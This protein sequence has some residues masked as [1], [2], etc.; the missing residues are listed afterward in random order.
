VH[1][2]EAL[3]TAAPIRRKVAPDGRLESRVR[4]PT[5]AWVRLHSLDDPIREA[6]EI[7]DRA[8]DGRPAPPIVTAI[9]VGTAAIVDEL[10]RRHPDTRILALELF[11]DVP[12]ALRA[13]ARTADVGG[14][15]TMVATGPEFSL[16]VTTW[17]VSVLTTDPLIVVQPIAAYYWPELV[18][19]ARRAARQ[20]VYE[21]RANEEA[22]ERLAPVYL[23]N[24][25]HNLPELL[26]A[27]DVSALDGMAEGDPVVLCGAGPSLDA[28]I[29]SLRT[30]RDRTWLVAIDTA[31]RPLLTAGIL[32]DLVVSIDPSSLNGRHL[33]D[34]PTRARPWL[35]A[36]MSLDPHAIRAF[37]GRIFACRLGAADPWPWL[38]SA[39][40]SATRVRAWGSVLTSACD[41]VRRMRPARVAFAAI[42]LAY[43][44]GQPYCRGTS[45]EADWEAQRLRDGLTSVDEVWKRR[46]S[47]HHLE[48]ADVNG[49]P[50]HTAPH[51]L[52]FRNWVRTFVA[53]EPSCRYANVTGAGILHGGRI[54]QSTLERWLAGPFDP[55]RP[56]AQLA[57]ASVRVQRDA[58][59]VA[60]AID[61]AAAGDE[62]WQTWT[63]RVPRIE[64]TRISRL[65][66]LSAREIRVRQGEDAVS[67][68]SEWIDVPFDPS[69][70][71]SKEPM[72]WQVAE[73]NVGTFAYKVDGKTMALSFK[74]NHSTLAGEP[75]KE[76]FMRLPG[77]YVAAR[78]AANAVWVGSRPI[79]ET[80]Y[81]TV[82]PGHDFIV[83]HRG[84]E[85]PFP[86]ERDDFFVFGQLLLEVQ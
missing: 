1:V 7:V 36:E 4:T 47:E 81:A 67:G 40:M 22:R 50:A 42:D 43:T 55:S 37:A 15:L 51:L 29:P 66:E 3:A 75:S 74:I 30:C 46:L 48:E 63:S 17:P 2:T 53:E 33:L 57:A 20:Y 84:N 76:L 38:E 10:V 68:S 79:K 27:P 82:H 11:T 70:F 86:L 25:L 44:E 41:I 14:G 83:V 32:P 52:A 39:G 62:P 23:E 28:L 71:F 35:V 59:T 85:E 5:G 73:S 13:Q 31:L 21:R 24:T 6:R 9:G 80:G 19:R 77:N 12:D 18:E 58:S 49:Q 64:R 26:R 61:A 16:P 72:S 45:F 56:A 65:L 8:L 69:H 54:E 34:L 60:A 78:G